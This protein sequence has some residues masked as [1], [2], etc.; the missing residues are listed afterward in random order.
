MTIILWLIFEPWILNCPVSFVSRKLEKPCS[1]S[2]TLR[3]ESW[4]HTHEKA[5]GRSSAP[6][7]GYDNHSDLQKT[8]NSRQ[9]RSPPAP[10]KDEEK[11]KRQE[12]GSVTGGAYE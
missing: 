1:L 2:N 9:T 6:L 10:L 5:A 12:E 8:V 4:W 11:D 3:A 7:L